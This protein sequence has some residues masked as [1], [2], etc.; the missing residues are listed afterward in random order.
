MASTAV[1]EILPVE[2]KCFH[3]M[4]PA[5]RHA[6]ST[7]LPGW[8]LMVEFAKRDPAFWAQFHDMY[9]RF[10]IHRDVKQVIE[11]IIQRTKLEDASC[12]PFPSRA[13]AEACVEW[14]TPTKRADGLD[15]VPKDQ[16][17]IR[18]FETNGPK[19]CVVI[20]PLAHLKLVTPYWVNTG[21]GISSRLAEDLLN[22]IQSLRDG[23]LGELD[24]RTDDTPISQALRQRISG[25]VNR[26]PVGPPRKTE[27]SPEDVYLY[28][29]GMS[30]IVY[31]HNYLTKWRDNPK[32]KTVM[33]GF[34]FHQTV[35]IFEWWGAGL[36]FFP[37]G[38]ELDE[39]EKYLQDEETNGS[40]VQAVWTEFPSNPLLVSSD[41]GR[42]RILADNFHFALVVDDTVGSFCNVDVLPIADVIV[43]SLTK[44][45]SGY[46]DV[47]GGSAVLNSEAAKYA[48]FK[49]LFDGLYADDLY[50]R[51]A[52]VLLSNSE[53]YLTRSTTLN[54]NA[55][56][57]VDYLHSLTA[58]PTSCISKVF[59]PTINSTLSNYE[60]Y[61]R[62][63]TSEFI[64]GY[65]C[66]FSIQFDTLEQT[67]EFYNHF[68][69]HHGPH[70]GAHRTLAMPYVRALYGDEL[71]KVK[72]WGLEQTQIRISVG[73]ESEKVL[74]E[75]F[76][77]ALKKADAIKSAK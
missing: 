39:L 17:S 33:F 69:V 27:V 58:D 16:I 1:M 29:T 23:S 50:I 15:P 57:L 31:V 9:P 56:A 46:A 51:D 22:N 40:P 62:A 4:P 48:E 6:I 42:L 11:L 63:P 21:T 60:A 67:I 26:A 72:A 55:A 24:N 36:K 70:L 65:G 20:F 44:S 8:D 2:T 45:F 47:M 18:E 32:S 34:P 19:L 54:N 77:H 10:L 28:Q 71:E 76:K 64:P 3:A 52:E 66:L 41:L 43:T 38:T 59:Y 14:V 74:V 5:P 13:V 49:T 35:H 25:L 61:K 53:D 37:L 68:H 7:H 30:A 75:T 73:L 12:L